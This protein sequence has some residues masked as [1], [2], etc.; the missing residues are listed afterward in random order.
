M[1]WNGT[2]NFCREGLCIFAQITC[3]VWFY[4]CMHLSYNTHTLQE[5]ATVSLFIKLMKIALLTIV[6]LI[7]VKLIFSTINSKLVTLVC[8]CV[9]VYVCVCVCVSVRVCLY[10]CVLCVC[11]CVCVCVC[12]VNKTS[13]STYR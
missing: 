13:L 8:V 2:T 3:P 11:V 10:V 12:T 5:L 7:D 1:L 6:L 4:I 9:C